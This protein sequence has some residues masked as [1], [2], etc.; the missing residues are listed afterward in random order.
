[1]QT[2][3]P[4]AWAASNQLVAIVE[5]SFAPPGAATQHPV[6]MPSQIASP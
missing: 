2:Q 5:N 4:F 1:L 3:L 6:S